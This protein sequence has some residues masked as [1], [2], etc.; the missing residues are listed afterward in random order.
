MTS[1]GRSGARSAISSVSSDQRF[2]DRVGHFQQDLAVVLGL[3]Q[4]P[5]GQPLRQRQLLQHRGDVRR[6][7]LV[8]L[9]L[10]LH[11]VLP[12]HQR[13]DQIVARHVLLVHQILDQPVLL[14]HGTH[15]LQRLLDAVGSFPGL[16]LVVGHVCR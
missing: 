4:V 9:L 13:L 14:Q 12:V 1:W 8:Q 16:G 6:V 5:D 7:Q 15:L 2:A 3:D 11:Q 10:Q